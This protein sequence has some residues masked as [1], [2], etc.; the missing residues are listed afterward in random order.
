M[1]GDAPQGLC[2]NCMLKAGFQ[3][4]GSMPEENPGSTGVSGAPF[5]PPTPAQLAP[6]F[7]DLEILELVG[8]GGMGVVYK[9]RQKHLDRLV[10]LKILSPKIGRDP[11]FRERFAREARA[12]A[13]LSHPHIVAVHDFGQTRSPAASSDEG[14]EGDNSLYYFVM[15]FVDGANLRRLLDTGK[16]SPKEALA[17][18]PPICDALQYA[19]DHGVVHRDIKPE[20]VLLDK[21]GRVKIADFGLAKLIG[22]ALPERSEEGVLH[23]APVRYEPLTATGHVMGTPQYMAPEQ[24]EHPQQVDHRADI[25]SL[26]VVFY[27]MLTGELPV[28]RFAPP[29]KKVQIDVRLDEV[30]LRALEKEPARRY[31]QASQIKTEVETIAATSR[32]G[33]SWS[34]PPDADDHAVEQA[35]QQVRGPAIGLL[36]VGIVH[37]LTIPP[38]LLALV[39]W[40][41]SSTA[42]P[43]GHPSVEPS[44]VPLSLLIVGVA[45]VPMML[46][47]LIIVAALKMK[48]LQA[49]GLAITG[50]ILSTVSPV[51]LI[52]LPIGI[53]ALVVLSQRDVRRAFG[54]NRHRLPYSPPVVAAR[55]RKWVAAMGCSLFLASVPLGFFIGLETDGSARLFFFLLLLI[56]LVALELIFGLIGWRSSV[57]KATVFVAAPLLLILLSLLGAAAI[58]EFQTIR[59]DFGGW[60]SVTRLQPA[61]VRVIRSGEHEATQER[62]RYAII[63]QMEAKDVHFDDLQVFVADMLNSATV[64]VRGLYSPSDST[65]G[66]DG[67]FRMMRVGDGAWQGE[68]LSIEFRVPA[69]EMPLP[70]GRAAPA[71]PSELR[72]VAPAR[73][74]FGPVIEQ[75][76]TLKDTG[77]AGPI[78]LDIDS[79]ELL[80]PPFA[81]PVSDM[82]GYRYFDGL[83]PEIDEPPLK[84]WID[85]SGADLAIVLRTNDWGVLGLE[86]VNLIGLDDHPRRLEAARPLTVVDGWPYVE[87]RGTIRSDTVLAM[88]HQSV[89]TAHGSAAE[90]G[91][92]C[93]WIRTRGGLVGVLEL[94]GFDTATRGV[95]IRYK[96][97][98]ETAGSPVEAGDG[99]DDNSEKPP[100]P[101]GAV[102]IY[103]VDQ[104]TTP[105]ELSDA[106]RD[107]LLKIIDRRINS[108]SQMLARVGKRDNGRIEVALLRR[109]EEDRG[110]VERLLARSGMLEFRVLAS[111]DADK[112][113][114]DRALKN[115][116]STELLDSSKNRL[117]WWVPVHPDAEEDFAGY[118]DIARRT[119]KRDDRE[120]VEV[121]VV[122]DPYNVT[123]RYLT[124][125]E[126]DSDPGGRPTVSFT[127]N[128]AG[129]RLFGKLTGDHL[130][131]RS[132]DVRYR[133][134]IILD[135]ELF[136]APAIQSAI[137]NKGVITGSFT[138]DEVSD[139]A[140]ILNSGSL[141]VRLRLV[142][143]NDYDASGNPK[144]KAA[145]EAYEEATATPPPEPAARSPARTAQF[146]RHPCPGS[147]IR[148]T[149]PSNCFHSTDCRAGARM[150]R[151]KPGSPIMGRT[152][153]Y[154]FA[155][156]GIGLLVAFVIV[157][158]MAGASPPSDTTAITLFLSTVLAGTGA[159]A[160]AIV[161]AVD[162]FKRRSQEKE[163]QV[164]QT[165]QQR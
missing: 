29:S 55:S 150:R 50:S 59:H 53:W 98:T 64:T 28:G 129:G 80:K 124:R 103:E 42:Q 113:L 101:Q 49:Y 14:A 78:F 40:S 31:Q 56:A 89:P 121:L 3:T 160:G 26:G 102:L 157:R 37:L 132:A 133:A 69:A 68:F 126:P 62:L 1:P 7:P 39:Y 153:L 139:L 95:R 32:P 44:V 104:K 63:R 73:N 161:G 111:T 93:C 41:L 86:T 128:Q 130:P 13:M 27:Q 5:V 136:S 91:G 155:G 140:E 87:G 65:I 141:P 16:L 119:R 122:A 75:T 134:G 38:A 158:M 12:M 142:E 106:D 54:Q 15:E 123:G 135:G 11:A 46:S 116:S 74:G 144:A 43:L 88:V 52:G 107:E 48:R 97:V 149:L 85:E 6:H 118:P 96:M 35:R 100:K 110:R 109:S 17:I 164:Q 79:G 152:L 114:V 159:I 66:G 10:A 120:V 20:N 4:G 57:G 163:K 131:D 138:K 36:V 115:D 8:H 154:L 45:L 94:R 127:F 61:E 19:H 51:G 84:S 60:P 21:E 47:G 2:P 105:A 148:A 143:G 33:A 108:G 156:A 34:S 83:V 145:L 117:A 81:L 30:V 9:A 90:A 22:R 72:S 23:D 18:V 162:S 25:Y 67:E 82:S 137:F 125:A 70:I 92:D 71:A 76:V 146:P 58:H 24:I 112:D 77:G 147:A 151:R 165:V 99:M